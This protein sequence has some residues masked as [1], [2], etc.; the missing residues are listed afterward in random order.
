MN[1]LFEFAFDGIPADSLGN[2]IIGLIRTA[3]QVVDA[4]EDGVDLLPASVL[5]P[6]YWR[7]IAARS[8]DAA[9][10]INFRMLDIGGKQVARPTLIMMH[11]DDMSDFSIVLFGGDCKNAGLNAADDFYQWARKISERYCVTD[12]YGGLDAAWDANTRL[13]SKDGLGPF[14]SMSDLDGIWEDDAGEPVRHA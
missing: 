11:Y 3:D 5:D 6:V 1:E 7:G 2:L 14:L 13:F 9:C 10:I 8:G 4:M 12:F